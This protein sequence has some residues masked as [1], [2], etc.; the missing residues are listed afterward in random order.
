MKPVRINRLNIG[1]VPWIV[2]TVSTARALERIPAI[3]KRAFDLVE[4]RLDRIG[5]KTLD[6]DV[7]CQ[8]IEKKGIPVLLTIRSHREGGGWIGKDSPRLLLYKVML[9]HVSAI[10]VEINSR[11]FNEAARVAHRAGKMII[12]SFHDFRR[13]PPA[14]VLRRIIASGRKKGADI[15]K[16]AVWIRSKADVQTL[17]SLFEKDQRPLCLIGMGPRGASSRVD[18][19][20][21]GSCLTYGFVDRTAAPGQISCRE[22]AA[23]LRKK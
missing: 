1:K 19:V 6:W 15:V 13:T 4:V 23:R 14:R 22:L 21:A 11:I 20:K 2:G 9:P 12:G 5:C 18:L 16:L 3:R 8:A 7:R 10:D 17:S